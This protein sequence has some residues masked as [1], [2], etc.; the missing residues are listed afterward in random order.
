[1][2]KLR[3]KTKLMITCV[4]VIAVFAVGG[5]V[6]ANSQSKQKIEDAQKVVDKE[7]GTL[8]D[9]TKELHKLLDSKDNEFL[10][11]DV[12]SEKIKELQDEFDQATK[13]VS[14]ISIDLKKLN[15]ETYASEET[16]TK[17]LLEKIEKNYAAQNAV[18]KLYQFDDKSMVLNGSKVTKDLAIADDLKKVY[19]ISKN[20]FFTRQKPNNV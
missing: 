2:E 19:S 14:S 12:T 5:G 6:Y 17:E 8:R 11:K 9:I 20:R 3:T 13:K 15:R 18:N 10:A 1:M 4:G 7:R 16:D